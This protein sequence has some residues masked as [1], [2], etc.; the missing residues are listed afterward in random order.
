M[1]LLD[2]I[3]LAPLLFGLGRGL[4]KGLFIELASLVSLF[5]GAFMAYLFADDVYLQL[6][7]YVD[8]PGIGTKVASYALVFV[9]VVIAVYLLARA[10][11]KMMKLVAL[12]FVNR[13]LGGLFGLCKTLIL[14]L[15][16]VYFTSGFIALQ[17]KENNVLVT[18]SFL[19]S[20]FEEYSHYVGYYIDKATETKEARSLDLNTLPD[21]NSTP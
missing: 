6:A 4:F 5:G 18:E 13:L 14:V 15:I 17:R 21:L 10:L 20:Y 12:G 16:V 7:K 8:D 1:N 11:T 2:F 9:A 3:L 19:I